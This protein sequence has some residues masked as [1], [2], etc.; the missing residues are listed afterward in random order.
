MKKFLMVLLVPILLAS[1]GFAQKGAYTRPSALGISFTF[2]D[3]TTAQRIRSSSLSSVLKD[4]QAAKIK[5]MAP[6]FALTYFKGLSNHVDLATTLLGTFVEVP[7]PDDPFPSDHFLLEGD[8][9]VN[10]KMF[11]DKY[12]F[13]PYLSAGVGAG[14]YKKKVGAFVPLGAGLKFNLFDEAAV[15]ITS[16]YRIPVTTETSTYHFV[17]GIGIAGII[18]RKKEEPLKTVEIPQ[19]P[20]DTDGDGINDDVDKCP[21]VAGTAKYEGC[22]VPDTDSDSINDE[23]DKCP[24][25]AGTAKY[26]GC[27]VPDTDGDGINDEQDKCPTIAGTAKYEGCPIPDTDGDGINDEEDRCPQLAGVAANNGCPEVKEE[28]IK[29]VDYAATK[30]YFATASSKLLA[31]SFTGLND[32]V[33]IMES[34]KDIKLSIEG[35]TDNVGKDDYNQT[36]SE[37]RANSVRAYLLSKGIDE[38]RLT[39]QG[40]GETQPLADNKTAA[41]KSKNRRVV[42]RADY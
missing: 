36:L 9:S 1:E 14:L 13:T 11:P 34:D 7:L 38:S 4:K 40:F 24:T 23:L 39:S 37:Q 10:L 35:H 27:P 21:E 22:P 32:V 18:G 8:A 3:Y 15:Y 41:G 33:K 17:H 5:D 25:V 20:K 16:Q 28:V 19:A 12:I 2:T 6:G 31:K 26:D 29:R 30:I 42:M